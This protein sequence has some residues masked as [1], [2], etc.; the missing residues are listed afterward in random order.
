M[1]KITLIVSTETEC[2]AY[3]YW[4]IID[5]QQNFY[6]D[7]DGVHAIANMI[8][9]PFFSREEAQDFLDR[10][11]YNFGRGAKVYCC[12]GCYS[13]SWVKANKQAL[14]DSDITE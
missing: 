2:T 9:G 12:S 5:P 7:D 3:P 8:T 13:D 6:K 1:K 14:A 11:H 10:T 4:M